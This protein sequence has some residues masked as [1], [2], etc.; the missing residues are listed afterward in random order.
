M[1]HVRTFFTKQIFSPNPFLISSSFTSNQSTFFKKKLSI[2]Q[3]KL[4]EKKTASKQHFLSKRNRVHWTKLNYMRKTFFS[5][6]LHFLMHIHEVIYK[7]CRV[8]NVFVVVCHKWTFT[9]R[10]EDRQP[11][12]E[13]GAK[14]FLSLFREVFGWSFYT[15]CLGVADW[16]HL[17]EPLSVWI[18]VF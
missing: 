4:T 13:F 17:C 18:E 6:D 5:K 3:I 10:T 8:L 16:E 2:F 14:A 9:G 11:D 7:I 12:R 1:W 15:R